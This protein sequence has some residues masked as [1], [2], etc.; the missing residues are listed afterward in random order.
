MH[1]LNLTTRLS[2]EMGLD[3]LPAHLADQAEALLD[4]LDDGRPRRDGRSAK[5]KT[6]R[7]RT[8]R[9]ADLKRRTEREL[10]NAGEG[11]HL[12]DHAVELPVAELRPPHRLAR[13]GH[14][15]HDASAHRRRLQRLQTAATPTPHGA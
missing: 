2:D 6:D 13:T 9:A 15:G 14:A 8:E 5:R 4:G 7:S 11:L 1:T 10:K 12:T 3:E